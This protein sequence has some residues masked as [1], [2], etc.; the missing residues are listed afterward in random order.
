MTGRRHE[1]ARRG[2]VEVYTVEQVAVRCGVDIE[3]VTRLVS[4]GVVEPLPERPDCFAPEV[5]L[6]VLKVVRLQRDLGVNLQGAAVAL[7]LLREIERL[8]REL[9]QLRGR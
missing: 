8:E 5:T 3:F 2:A 9:R 7:D 4:H 1:G 6:R